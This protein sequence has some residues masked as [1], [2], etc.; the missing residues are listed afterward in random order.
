MKKTGSVPVNIPVDLDRRRYLHLD[1][2]AIVRFEV[3]TGKPVFHG[4]T[5]KRISKNDAVLWLWA[6]LATDDPTLKPE[7]LV[8]ILDTNKISW[9]TVLASVEK[10]NL[11]WQELVTNSIVTGGEI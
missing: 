2:A 1:L 11:A 9:E 10:L 6:C 4:K 5:R 7:D 8:K 3:I